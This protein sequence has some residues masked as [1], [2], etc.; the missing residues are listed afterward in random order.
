M[1]GG[2]SGKVQ[3]TRNGEWYEL[4]L[5]EISEGILAVGEEGEILYANRSAEDLIGGQ[6]EKLPGRKLIDL[7]PASSD[8]GERDIRALFRTISGDIGDFP[9]DFTVDMEGRTLS[10]K[11]FPF[12]NRKGLLILVRDETDRRR[13]EI[14]L[15]Q[16]QKMEAI[17][18]LASG[19]AHDFNNLLMGIQGQVSLLLLHKDP[20]RCRDRLRTIERQIESGTRL[21]R[22]LLG[23]VRG[24]EEDGRSFDLN[25]LVKDV[26]GTFGRIRKEYPVILDLGRDLYALDADRA[27]IEQVLLNL[28]MNAVQAM[29]SGGEITVRTRNMSW[30]KMKALGLDGKPGDYVL[31]CI[32]DKGRG[33]EKETLSRIFEPFFTTRGNRGGHGLGLASVYWIVKGNGG[34]I[35]VESE[36]GVGTAFKMY[37]PAR[38]DVLPEKRRTDSSTSTIGTISGKGTVLS[39]DDEETVRKVGQEMLEVMG[40]NVI[41]AKD[42]E[43]AIELFM[44]YREKIDIVLLDMVMPKMSGA[45]VFEKLKEI[46]PG[47]RVLLS[48]GY[49]IEGKAGEILKRGCDG[50]IQKP[51]KMEELASTLKA[52][53]DRN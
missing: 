35:E 10:L 2:D 28:Y 16:A 32:E 22:Q 42:G 7:F 43:D 15:Q 31:L 44:K 52:L 25:K 20:R 39:V 45:E 37:F 14:Q 48:S 13:L 19:I 24:S 3:A 6:R 18:T 26:L 49:S 21:T 17:G 36:Q 38:K 34:H 29:P 46:D 50:F 30:K 27:Q 23:F 1:A 5:N 40:Y 41:T 53:L 51:Y 12:R 47:V 9:S 8:D 33:I 4:A 11:A